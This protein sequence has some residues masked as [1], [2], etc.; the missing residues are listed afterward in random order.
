LGKAIFGQNLTNFRECC[1]LVIWV[2]L[3]A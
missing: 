1:S 2:D 3:V